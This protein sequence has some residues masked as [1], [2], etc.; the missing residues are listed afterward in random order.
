MLFNKV[1]E[2]DV[3]LTSA[4][5]EKITT[6]GRNFTIARPWGGAFAFVDNDLAS[7]K[8]TDNSAAWNKGW[9]KSHK[10]YNKSWSCKEIRQKQIKNSFMNSENRQ[11][12][13]LSARF[14][15]SKNEAPLLCH[16]SVDSY[17]SCMKKNLS[18]RS[19]LEALITPKRI[20]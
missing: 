6:S 5:R 17:D 18:C 8:N 3:Q 12:N 1:A 20:M 4:T 9:E 15:P 11:N 14:L 16:K 19:Y 13:T 2:T 7:H 10:T